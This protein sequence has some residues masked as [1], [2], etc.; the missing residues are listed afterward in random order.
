MAH[1]PNLT[2]STRHP[3]RTPVPEGVV[4]DHMQAP[5]HRQIGFVEGYTRTGVVEDC[6]TTGVAVVGVVEHRMRVVVAVG[7]SH[8]THASDGILQQAHHHWD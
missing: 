2:V 1:H 8:A 6:R 3:V 7:L 4:A 5:R